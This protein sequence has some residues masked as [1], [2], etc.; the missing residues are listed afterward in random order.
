MQPVQLVECPRDAIQGWPSPISTEDKLAYY[1]L[2]LDVG[3]DTID[4]GSF[5][6]HKAIPQMADTH[7]VIRGLQ[8]HGVL[9]GTSRILVIV[10]N[11]RGAKD[12]VQYEGIDDLGFP[13]SISEHFQQ[14]NTG[15]SIDEALNRLDRI[16][17]HADQHGKRLVIY[18]SMGF[19]NPFGDDWSPQMLVDWAG[20]LAE[21]YNPGVLAL[22]DTVGKADEEV[23]RSSFEALIPAYS[24]I[25]FGAHL[26]AAPWDA[27]KKI[28]AAQDAGCLRFDGAIRGIGGCPLAQ[29]E[30]VGN[31][32]TEKVVEHF[33]ASGLW[34]VRNE[35]AWADAQS[36]AVDLF[37]A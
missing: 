32:P 36:Y 1:R 14:R 6:S 9:G 12:A 15:S 22:S 8:D 4:I 34:S 35:K 13:F 5:V 27:L 26:H 3:F 31:M 30:L 18:L 16:Q 10:A 24:E 19:G 37:Q 25:S 7:R 17:H 33:C 20:K 29:D 23:I 21:R 2:L 11:E 28:K